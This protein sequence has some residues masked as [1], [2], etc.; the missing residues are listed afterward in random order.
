MAENIYKRYELSQS[1]NGTKIVQIARNAIGAVVFR[2]ES[3]KKLKLAIDKH[4]ERKQKEA[5]IAAQAKLKAQKLAAKQA[6]KKNSRGLFQAKTEA[7]QKP[8]VASKSK[9]AKAESPRKKHFW[10]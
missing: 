3:V 7:N 8:K 5:E 4:I 1:L 9:P 6:K 10:G 2:E